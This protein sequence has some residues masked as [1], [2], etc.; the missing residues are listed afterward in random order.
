MGCL[1]VK[2]QESLQGMCLFRLQSFQSSRFCWW[3]RWWEV[4]C[5]HGTKYIIASPIVMW[6]LRTRRCGHFFFAQKFNGR[7]QGTSKHWNYQAVHGSI[8]RGVSDGRGSERCS[9]LPRGTAGRCSAARPSR[10][11]ANAVWSLTPSQVKG[12]RDM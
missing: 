8:E 2:R 12:K 4:V 10:G 3:P 6:G 7:K 1:K 5:F 11:S 9:D